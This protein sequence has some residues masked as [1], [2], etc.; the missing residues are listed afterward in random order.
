MSCQASYSAGRISAFMPAS[1]PTR[2]TPSFSTTWV[3]R[4]SST[5]ALGDQIAAGLDRQR[6]ARIRGLDLGQS[7]A[8]TRRDRTARR[9]A[10]TESAGRRRCRCAVD[11]ADAVGE[12][13]PVR[14]RPRASARRL[15]AAA[16]MRMQAD[17]AHVERARRAR[18]SCRAAP[19]AGR[20][21]TP[22]PPVTTLSWWPSPRPRSRR[23]H[24][25]AAAEDVRP[26]LQRIDVVERDRDAA[27]ERGVVFGAR[28]EARREQHARRDR[29]RAWSRTRA[30]SSPC[31]THSRPK[32]SSTSTQQDRGM[33]IGLD[34]VEA[35]IDRGDAAS[36][37][38]ARRTHGRQ[39]VD[40][41]RRAG[42]G[43]CASRRVAL[44]L[45]PRRRALAAAV[46]DLAPARPEYARRPPP[47]SR[48]RRS[49]R[50]AGRGSSPSASALVDHE[51]QVEVVRRLR[52]QVHALAAERG[53][54][55]R[56][57][58]AA[59]SACRGRPA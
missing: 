41:A 42:V 57:A 34:R 51:G 20:T 6:V 18:R 56:T 23:S 15:D 24:S 19:A 3:T 1:R 59:A 29:V 55:R 25:V 28:R 33:R 22:L 45:P 4:A 52:D 39:V 53:P 37:H 50:H 38:C 36:A 11:A 5:P 2:R 7:R 44:G 32:P 30:A 10:C 47:A 17:D 26:A 58:C 46:S 21:S 16:E 40:V 14:R 35:A 54:A 43:A 13:P 48:R 8:P 12:R 31:D 9:P 49:A 27:R